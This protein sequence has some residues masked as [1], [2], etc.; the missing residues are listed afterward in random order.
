MA[1]WCWES[2]DTRP[3]AVFDLT[4]RV[5]PQLQLKK[6]CDIFSEKF[7]I[8]LFWIIM[9][10]VL[11]MQK[12]AYMSIIVAKNYRNKFCLENAAILNDFEH[13]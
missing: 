11:L 12:S 4:V 3:L 9:N 5:N 10:N 2:R 6:Y 8:L 7:F 1:G 13:G